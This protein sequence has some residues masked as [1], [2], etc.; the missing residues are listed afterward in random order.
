VQNVDSLGDE[1]P[2]NSRRS[3]KQEDL[4]DEIE[5]SDA[6]PPPSETMLT[7]DSPRFEMDIGTIYLTDAIILDS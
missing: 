2:D 5:K 4:D 1:K 7:L 3:V 6:P